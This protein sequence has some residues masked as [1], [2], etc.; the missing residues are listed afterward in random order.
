MNATQGLTLVVPTIL[1]SFSFPIS[2]SAQV[3]PPPPPTKIAC[4]S[5]DGRTTHRCG[6][7]WPDTYNGVPYE[8]TCNC[9]T[10]GSNDCRPRPQPNAPT[11]SPSGSLS[12]TA[13][14]TPVEQ[15]PGVGGTDPASPAGGVTQPPFD[16]EAFGRDKRELLLSLKGGVSTGLPALKVGTTVQDE[17]TETKAQLQ[18]MDPATMER[19]RALISRRIAPPNPWCNSIRRSLKI[20]A[21]PLPDKA[22]AQLQPGDVLLVAPEDDLSLEAWKGHYLRLVDK[23]SSW[24][25]QSRA[26]HTC[27][28]LREV[29]GKKF[30]MDNI[31]GEGPRIKT[32]DEIVDEYGSRAIDVARPKR[33]GVAQPVSK[34]DG[35]KLWAAARELGIRELAAERERPG[36]WI[37]KTNYGLYGDD[38]MVCSEASRWA[39]IR[40]GLQIP[41]TESPFKKLV[42][43][44]FGPANFYSQEQYFLISPLEALSTVTDTP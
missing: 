7:S 19:Q 22:F 16:H 28:F 1:A 30:F 17:L 27:I 3:P 5:M 37:D 36:N 6:D 23:L 33:I 12:P 25:W 21:P 29:K 14:P 35:D 4:Y 26:S 32:G 31:P 38:N 39:L 11:D 44:Y 42:G 24:E 9:T 8:C 43:V 13:T 10:S 2:S 18:K 20:K 15:G 41:N 34:V 40:A